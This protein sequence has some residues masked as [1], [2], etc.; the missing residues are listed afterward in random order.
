MDFARPVQAV[1][2]GAQGRILAVLAETT[3]EL[4][5][6]MIA[7]LAGVSTAQASRLLPSLVQLGVLERREA[8]PSQLFRFVQEN[9]AARAISALTNARRT[10]LDELGQA[11]GDLEPPPACV[12]VFGSFARG[13]ADA[14]SDLDLIVV[15]PSGTDE[16]DERWRES[17]NR[18]RLR[19]QRLTGNRVEI[20]ETD[21][22]K[23]RGLLR[24]RTPLWLDVRREGIVV[25]GTGLAD[26]AGRRSA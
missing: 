8:P 12:I 6:R 21:A 1:I 24:G 16:D 11:A 20:V 14:E 13:E 19:A 26:L 15:R 4:N 23:V 22:T 17:V 3:A 2:P 25:F 5:L 7:R 18:L 10:V 9:V